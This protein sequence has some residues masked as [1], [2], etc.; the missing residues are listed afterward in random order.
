VVLRREFSDGIAQRKKR[1][2]GNEA[3]AKG[4]QIE[5]RSPHS[6][7]SI[8]N[9][10]HDRHAFSFDHRLQRFRETALDRK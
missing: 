3:C 1:A 2:N 9:I 8:D 7:P 10:V 5:E 4:L 6:R